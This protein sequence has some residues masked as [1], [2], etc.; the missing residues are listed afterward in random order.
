MKSIIKPTEPNYKNISE[1]LQLLK[2]LNK[3]HY[4]I[5]DQP[6]SS[7]EKVIANLS[8]IPTKGFSL[9]FEAPSNFKYDLRDIH[10]LK[11]STTK[12]ELSVKK[13]F[14]NLISPPFVTG[15]IHEFKSQSFRNEPKYYRLFIP[16][17]KKFD[18]HFYL[19]L[20]S[21][22]TNQLESVRCVRV[23]HSGLNIDLYLFDE[24][25]NL[26]YLIIDASE[27]MTLKQFQDYCFST[28]VATG[29]VTGKMPQD[30]GYF[31]GYDQSD[32]KNPIHFC[33][34]ELRDSLESIYSPIYS[35]P[36]GYIRD[37]KSAELYKGKLRTLTSTEFSKLCEWTHN[38]IEFSSILLLIIES[39]TSSLLVMPTGFS[40]ALE[41]L[42]DLLMRENKKA[43][44]IVG[45]QLAKKLKQELT[46]IIDAHSSELTTDGLKILK[47]KIEHINQIPNRSKLTKPFENLGFKLTDEDVK[48]IEHRNDFL[49]GRLTL[50]PSEDV[51][52]TNLEIYYVALRLYTLLAVLILKF[53]GYDNKILNHP[54]LQEATSGKKID[55]E[56]YRQ[57]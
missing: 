29:Y 7:L 37:R 32:L 35:N 54:K 6:N 34:T 50:S 8:K 48:A 13:G 22:R 39:C 15:H 33:Y 55:E 30:E 23:N 17:K 3:D 4:V 52:S 49:H 21:Y 28:L 42:T 36:H 47:A 38:S 11:I 43:S 20:F 10:D 26:H 40:V 12:F 24:K 51:H 31:F 44:P 25:D 41:G 53:V 1:S 9:R 45:K 57:L 2:E 27:R 46:A 14:I 16:L 19:S 56:F 5:F 18:F